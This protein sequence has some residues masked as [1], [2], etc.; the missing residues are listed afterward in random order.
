MILIRSAIVAFIFTASTSYG[1]TSPTTTSRAF[2]SSSRHSLQTSLSSTSDSA[3]AFDFD[4]AIIG[5]G[6]G[7]HGAALHSRSQSLQTAVF[8]GGDVGGT[9]V[10]R[11]CVPS[12]ALLAA[13]GRVREMQNSKHLS[14]LGIAVEGKVTFEREGIASHAKSLAQKVK[15]NLEASLVGLGVQVI[16]GR[17]ILTGKPHEI[18][19]SATGKVYTAKVSVF[20]AKITHI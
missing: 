8:A 17:G 19:D 16:E 12:K 5:C 1:F 9:C 15:G 6:V 4:V 20:L 7:G 11:G 10:N 13:S 14:E 18:Q 2:V 3:V